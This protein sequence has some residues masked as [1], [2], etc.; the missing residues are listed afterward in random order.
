MSENAVK[1]TH[2]DLMGVMIKFSF[3]PMVT[4]NY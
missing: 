1:L 4:I 3:F 2:K